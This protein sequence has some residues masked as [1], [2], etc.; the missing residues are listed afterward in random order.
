L[1]TGS[2]RSARSYEPLA[3][4]PKARENQ[5]ESRLIDAAAE[6]LENHV[7]QLR[8]PKSTVEDV[9]RS[10]DEGK[11]QSSLTWSD[12]KITINN[13]RYKSLKLNWESNQFNLQ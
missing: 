7:I 12:I 1:G 8:V 9:K 10:L 2:T 6:F 11:L 3:E 13:I 4:E 5:V